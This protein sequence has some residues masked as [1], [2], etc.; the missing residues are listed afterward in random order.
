MPG[1]G[2]G[3]RCWVRRGRER[4]RPRG[5]L[6]L[7]VAAA[8]LAPVAGTVR[9]ARTAATE[10]AGAAIY[11][12]PTGSDANPGTSSSPLRTLAAAQAM[13]RTLNATMTSDVTV[14]LE[15]GL[16]RLSQPLQLGPQDSGMNG[17]NVVWTAAPG[18][19]PVVGGSV[20]ITGW[21]FDQ[22]GPSFWAARVP[23]GFNTA[24]LYVNGVRAWQTSGAVPVGLTKTASGYQASSAPL[25]NWR[26]PSSLEFIY[27]GGQGQWAEPRCPIG[28]VSG[29]LISM[30][31]PC[32]NN[33]IQRRD[34]FVGYGRLG[35][36]TYIENAYELL[37]QPGQF[38][39]DDK[40]TCCTTFPGRPG[41][42]DRRRRSADAS[43]PG[44]GLTGRPA[45]RWHNITF[46][47]IEFA[48]ATWLRPGEPQG[49]SEIQAGYTITGKNG[50]AAPRASAISWRT[51]PAPT[52]PGR[53]SRPTSSSATTATSSF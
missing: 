48:Y 12:S 7:L 21:G 32:W 2:R 27:T 51:A 42:A 24:Q 31:Q 20:Q 10:F 8:L 6:P 37:N 19:V 33:S 44:A 16:F 11:V 18:A 49:F 25:S 41:H 53:R 17:H 13:V 29:R 47:D 36:P 34:N 14:Y 1:L 5:W 35:L 30:A 3:F 22:P 15:N 28:S 50:D 38:Y 26:N 43:G 23:D 40:L 9:G 39:L 52:A 4:V 45:G 46:S